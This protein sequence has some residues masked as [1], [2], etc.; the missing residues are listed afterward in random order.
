[1]SH[2]RTAVVALL[3]AALVAS[4]PAL[5]APTAFPQVINGFGNSN[6]AAVALEFENEYTC[7]GS[8]WR[9]RIIITAA[10]CVER[11]TG[12]F[13]TPRAIGV[14]PPG[15]SKRGLPA[16]V[17]VTEVIVNKKWDASHRRSDPAPGSSLAGSGRSRCP[18]RRRG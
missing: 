5:A 12:V 16:P 4:S 8:L 18:G 1:M 2:Y 11:S 13:Y 6:A 15:G 10:H 14:W 3:G 17:M 7:T 9:P